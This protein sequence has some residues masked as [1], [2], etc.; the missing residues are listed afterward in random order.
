MR[1]S[2]QK[3]KEHTQGLTLGDCDLKSLAASSRREYLRIYQVSGKME[4]SYGPA[5]FG[6]KTITQIFAGIRDRQNAEIDMI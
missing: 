1:K 4:N 2:S 6:T 5:I 3:E